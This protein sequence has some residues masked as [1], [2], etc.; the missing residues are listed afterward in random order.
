MVSPRW[1]DWCSFRRAL[2]ENRFPQNSHTQPAAEGSGRYGWYGD[3]RHAGRIILRKL[4]LTVTRS[5]R[6]LRY[7][8]LGNITAGVNLLY[9]C[10]FD[11]LT[12]IFCD[13]RETTV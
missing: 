10:V 2:M 9:D 11:C 8:A 4:L 1:T 6:G 5:H 13:L 3:D 12:L 7:T